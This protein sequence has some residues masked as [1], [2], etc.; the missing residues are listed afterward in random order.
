MKLSTLK[1]KVE[2]ND[3][4]HSAGKYF[5]DENSETIKELRSRGEKALL[6]IQKK[7]VYTIIG[8]Q[9]VHYLTSSGTKGQI[10]LKDLLEELTQ[11]MLRLGKGYF[12]MMF[13]YKNIILKN[14]DKVWLHN[15]KTMLGIW[16][17]ILWLEKLPGSNVDK[18]R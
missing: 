12:K 18:D 11:N 2:R 17:T 13:F 9:Y 16:N 10:L 7:G 3:F 4:I 1:A 15:S 5:I 6:G 14:G 8:E